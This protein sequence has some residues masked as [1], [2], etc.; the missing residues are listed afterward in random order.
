M[1]VKGSVRLGWVVDEAPTNLRNGPT[2]D[3]AVS[4]PLPIKLLSLATLD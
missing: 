4:T 3:G 1:G 2:N